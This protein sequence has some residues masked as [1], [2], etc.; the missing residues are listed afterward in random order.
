MRQAQDCLE[1]VGD[2]ID[3]EATLL[4]ILKYKINN[5]SCFFFGDHTD[6]F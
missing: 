2:I 5:R 4:Y 6:T 3:W 1:R